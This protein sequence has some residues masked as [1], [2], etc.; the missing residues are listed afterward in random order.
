M[1]DK[2]L[3][4]PFRVAYEIYSNP[5]M[6]YLANLGRRLAYEES[7]SPMDF[8]SSDDRA[9]TSEHD[10]LMLKELAISYLKDN[11]P[12]AKEFATTKDSDRQNYMRLK[13]YFEIKIKE[14]QLVS[15][16]VFFDDEA[17]RIDVGYGPKQFGFFFSDLNGFITKNK[18]K[19]PTHTGM[20]LMG[21]HIINLHEDY[22]KY[23]QNEKERLLAMANS[24]L[25]RSF[26]QKPVVE[27]KHESLHET[28]LL[29]DLFQKSQGLIMGE[30]H[31]QKSAKAFLVQ[32]MPYLSKLGVTQLYMEHLLCER[33]Q[34]LLDHEVIPEELK[35]YLKKLDKEHELK[36][37][38][39]FTNIVLT[40]KKLGIRVIA[41]DSEAT[42]RVG[43]DNTT[44][45]LI[46]EKKNTIERYQVMNMFML[47]RFRQYN[48]G[49]K[50]VFFGGSG[51]VATCYDV[52]GISELL[53]CPN[54]VIHS[55][56]EEQSKGRLEKD[57]VVEVDEEGTIMFDYLYHRNDT[58]PNFE[59]DNV[60]RRNLLA[61]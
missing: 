12:T 17:M 16:L 31:T 54:L 15:P 5:R 61:K 36:G 57:A 35:V 39:T 11:A 13:N 37:E 24:E 59:Q 38:G 25:K 18:I 42:Y 51:H 21:N 43:A 26:P 60:R 2:P 44:E 4:A 49:E 9:T 30:K 52:P 45:D 3:K 10:A 40:A 34:E 56:E 22:V 1:E 20:K 46:N 50:Y 19:N 41:V 32:N 33:H 58:S 23:L 28:L 8:V 27:V 48:Q 7:R 6:R 55:L 14:L 47:E 53:G 29:N